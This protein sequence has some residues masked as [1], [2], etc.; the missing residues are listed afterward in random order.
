MDAIA[1]IRER[2]RERTHLEF[3]EAPGFIEV[4]APSP[5]GFSVSLREAD[6]EYSVFFDSW[7]EHFEEPAD[8]V[9]CFG[10]GLSGECRLRVT[11]RGDTPVST[12]LEYRENGEWLTYSTT[13]LAFRPFWRRKR[14]ELLQN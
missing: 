6:G 11:Y 4:P 12:T 1:E 5:T 2:L 8:A 13:A 3:N 7:H 10:W 9:G 14:V